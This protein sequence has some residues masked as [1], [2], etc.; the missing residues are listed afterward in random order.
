MLMDIERKALYNLLR[1]NWLEEPSH[2]EVD[3]WQVADY[4]A[5]DEDVLFEELQ[6]LGIALDLDALAV[7]FED[8]N[9]PEELTDMLV[10]EDSDVAVEDSAYLLLFELW[11]RYV[12]EKP[13]IS[14]FCDELD[15]QINLYDSEEGAESEN[16]Q[17]ALA[18]LREVLDENTDE[19]LSPTDVMQTLE[20]N[21]AND[22]E[23][24]LYDFISDRI[25]EK[26]LSYAT[27]LIDGLYDYAQNVQWFDLLKARIV[28]HDSAPEAAELLS[29]IL[30]DASEAPTLELCVEL[31]PCLAQ[32]GDRS[33]FMKCFEMTLALLEEE[34][35]F[36]EL[37]VA[38]A[39]FFEFHGSDDQEEVVQN[40]LLQRND[41]ALDA[42]LHS[43]D[44]SIEALIQ[45]MNAPVRRI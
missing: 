24:F 19:G 2:T 8:C 6:Q 4:R 10:S 21:C 31:L 39:S 41:I 1:R 18:N 35:D 40:L 29:D 33:L 3:A 25:E 44:D 17:N 37:L 5:M 42:P 23:N 22:L 13:S 26:N 14:I 12:L 28:A 9:N 7:Y 16:I 34:A 27:E 45:I 43:D 15:H 20:S 30:E 36:K 32:V 11:R 38:C